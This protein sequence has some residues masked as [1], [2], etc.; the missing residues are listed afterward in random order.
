MQLPRKAI[1]NQPQEKKNKITRIRAEGRSIIEQREIKKYISKYFKEQYKQRWVLEIKLPG[2]AIRKHNFRTT[3][4]LIATPLKDEIKEVVWQCDGSKAPGYDGFNL[5]LIKSM[6]DVLGD[7]ICS[8]VVQFLKTSIMH[9]RIITAWA[10]L[11]PKVKVAV[12]VDEFRPISMIG[13]V[14]K[15]ISKLLTQETQESYRWLDR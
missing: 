5:N 7:D 14:Y 2:N 13:C 8:L 11:I 1:D 9:E 6:W 15:I 12:V 10:T 4:E 3:L